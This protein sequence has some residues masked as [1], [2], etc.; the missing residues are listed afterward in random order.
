MNNI[1]VISSYDNGYMFTV[2]YGKYRVQNDYYDIADDEL[3]NI[4]YKYMSNDKNLIEK[5]KEININPDYIIICI[6]GTINVISV[7]RP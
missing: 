5:L 6:D 7:P 3:L 4:C 1:L 2:Q